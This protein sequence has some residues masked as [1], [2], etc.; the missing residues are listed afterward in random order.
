MCVRAGINE[1]LT[2][3]HVGGVEGRRWATSSPGRP[4]EWRDVQAI[5]GENAHRAVAHLNIQSTGDGLEI[6]AHHARSGQY[7][8][9]SAAFV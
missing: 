1:K 4:A 7:K 6:V 5:G 9:R 3:E 2:P 8:S